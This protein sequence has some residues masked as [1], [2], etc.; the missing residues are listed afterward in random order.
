MTVRPETGLLFASLT[1]MLWLAKAVFTVVEMPAGTTIWVGGPAVWVRVA[2][3]ET[4]SGLG[5]VS[6]AVTE[7]LPAVVDEVTW[8]VKVPSPRL[9]TAPTVGPLADIVTVWPVTLLP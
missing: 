3:L 4:M 9:V 6:V 5:V 2:G 1:V 8:A 7:K